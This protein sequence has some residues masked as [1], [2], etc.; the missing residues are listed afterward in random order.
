M[1]QQIRDE[2]GRP[3]WYFDQCKRFGPGRPGSAEAFKDSIER[4]NREQRKAAE[5][6]RY[7]EHQRQLDEYEKPV[8]RYLGI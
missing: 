7:A 3:T 5:R 4:F 2:Q 6:K 1:K 8:S